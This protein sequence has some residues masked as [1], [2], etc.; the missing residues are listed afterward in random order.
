M[1]SL[2]IRKPCNSSK[3]INKSKLFSTVSKRKDLMKPKEKGLSKSTC[4]LPTIKLT[5]VQSVGVNRKKSLKSKN[6]EKLNKLYN[7]NSKYINQVKTIKK[8][9]DIALSRHFNIDTY[10]AN[11]LKLASNCVSYESVKSLRDDFNSMNQKIEGRVKL[12]SSWVSLAKQL[13]NIAPQHLLNK[14]HS[15]GHKSKEC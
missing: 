2:S 7:F 8:S 12:T 10:Q 9:N 1:Q 14:L 13:E 3:M 15:M 5:S 4:C 6:R 11:L